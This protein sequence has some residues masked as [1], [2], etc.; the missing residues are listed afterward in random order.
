MA[1]LVAMRS[2][3]PIGVP[4][5]ASGALTSVKMAVPDDRVGV[6]VGRAGRTILDIQQV[7]VYLWKVF[8]DFGL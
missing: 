3:L 7:N 5:V 2:P 4:L 8:A 1:P 6:I